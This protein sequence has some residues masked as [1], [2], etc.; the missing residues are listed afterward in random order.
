[1]TGVIEMLLA[2]E[3]K[4]FLMEATVFW[5]I[6]PS[7]TPCSIETASDVFLIK[8]LFPYG[9]NEPPQPLPMTFSVPSEYVTLF[10]ADNSPFS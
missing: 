1:M 3:E 9:E 5:V 2:S 7:S 4:S 10:F 6:E 8:T